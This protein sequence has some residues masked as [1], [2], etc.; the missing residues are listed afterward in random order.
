MIVIW[1]NF[2]CAQSKQA[3]ALVSSP[4][5][6][7]NRSSSRRKLLG[8]NLI[9]EINPRSLQKTIKLTWFDMRRWICFDCREQAEKARINIIK[10]WETG[11]LIK[12]RVVASGNWHGVHF[13]E[14]GEPERMKNYLLIRRMT[15]CS[16]EHWN[17]NFVSNRAR[18]HCLFG[19]NRFCFAAS[20]VSLRVC[21]IRYWV[22]LNPSH[23]PANP[24]T[25]VPTWTHD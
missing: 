12:F 11:N 23:R 6:C 2:T 4:S 10:R 20:C 14:G 15:I 8:E 16:M 18:V 24:P 13:S 5:L 19:A 22:D 9:S 25:K 3:R 7:K 1:F 17:I 21:V